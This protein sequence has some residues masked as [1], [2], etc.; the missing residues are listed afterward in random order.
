MGSRIIKWVTKPYYKTFFLIKK[1]F[2]FFSGKDT[3]AFICSY[4][5]SSHFL[6]SYFSTH[7][8]TQFKAL[9]IFI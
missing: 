3:A 8:H 7:A 1:H 4:T 9:P 6:L 2:P 5:E